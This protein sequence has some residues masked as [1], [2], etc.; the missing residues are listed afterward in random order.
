MKMRRTASILLG[1]LVVSGLLAP[2]V[3]SA[4]EAETLIAKEYWPMPSYGD[5][6]FEV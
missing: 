2:C 6:L 5:L 1:T 3:C 4:D